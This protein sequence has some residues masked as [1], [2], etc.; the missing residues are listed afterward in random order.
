MAAQEQSDSSGDDAEEDANDD[1]ANNRDNVNIAR[2]RTEE[3]K[4][5]GSSK[6][7]KKGKGES[8]EC[9]SPSTETDERSEKISKLKK[10]LKTLSIGYEE[11][12]KEHLAGTKADPLSLMTANK[13][14]F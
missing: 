11:G 8:D 3:K 6:E 4:G 12:K 2:G 1:Y 13:R 5:K 7:G 9:V 14:M 10:L